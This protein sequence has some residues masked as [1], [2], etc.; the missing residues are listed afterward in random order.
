MDQTLCAIC[1]EEKHSL[2]NVKC[3]NCL[4]CGYVNKLTCQDC[5]N[6][7]E[8]CPWCRSD[9]NANLLQLKTWRSA[10]RLSRVI[11]RIPE[12]GKKMVSKFS[13]TKIFPT[14]SNVV[15]KEKISCFDICMWLKFILS[16]FFMIVGI[17][18]TGFLMGML[19]CG[20]SNCVYCIIN[21]IFGVCYSTTASLA[22]SIALHDVRSESK[23]R[24]LTI[25]HVSCTFFFALMMIITFGTMGSCSFVITKCILLLFLFPCYVCITGKCVSDCASLSDG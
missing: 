13:K 11:T 1:C 5:L 21:G 22:I 16:C 12:K 14:S 9:I 4:E 20:K 10:P 24:F 19:W 3:P 8:N 6:Q 18:M 17:S 25:T 7:I 23:Y 2:Y 15:V